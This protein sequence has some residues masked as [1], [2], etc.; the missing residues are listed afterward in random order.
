MVTTDM[1]PV[2][3]RISFVDLFG[4][5]KDRVPA[6][7]RMA[8]WEEWKRIAGADIADYW[9]PGKECQGCKHLIG[10]DWCGLQQLPASVNPILS[11]RSGMIG[12]A[13]MGAGY[14]KKFEAESL[15]G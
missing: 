10:R 5:M 11:F 4:T 13:C 8:R 3:K 14:E 6:H 15:E 1:K 7:I 2:T 12:M 9:F